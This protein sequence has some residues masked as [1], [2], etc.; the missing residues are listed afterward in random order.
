M[1]AHRDFYQI[2][3]VDRTASQ[4]EIQRAYR[5]LARAHHPDVNHDP[6]A[7]TGLKTSRRP[8]TCLSDPDARRRYDA[9]GADFRQV[10]EDVDPDTAS[11][12][13]PRRRG[14]AGPV[15]GAGRPGPRGTPAF[16]E[17]I[18][19]EDLLGGLFGGRAAAGAG[20]LSLARIRKRISS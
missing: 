19:L 5:K 3:G 17:D 11:Y 1:A 13:G 9:F 8:R 14:G 4:D 7:G 16:G 20:D 18:D 2:L 12:P 15:R 6:G 10:P